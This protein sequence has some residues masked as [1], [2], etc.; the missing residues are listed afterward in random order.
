MITGEGLQSRAAV[1]VVASR[2][3]P[4]CGSGPPR[5]SKKSGGS[6]AADSRWLESVSIRFGIDWYECTIMAKDGC[7]RRLREAVLRLCSMW[8]CV[9]PPPRIILGTRGD[10]ALLIGRSAFP[11]PVLLP[12]CDQGAAT[13]TKP[14]DLVLRLGRLTTS[15]T[16]VPPYS[17][18]CFA[19]LRP[20]V[21]VRRAT[22]SRPG[23]E[24]RGPPSEPLGSAVAFLEL[25]RD[26]QSSIAASTHGDFAGRLRRGFQNSGLGVSPWLVRSL[27]IRGGA[28]S[29][30]ADQANTALALGAPLEVG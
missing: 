9:S 21:G 1:M 25:R 18:P 28:P 6:P 14:R 11:N 17:L 16:A 23:H 7:M 3:W 4:G 26:G 20:L 10:E 13:G 12:S 30:S 5:R 19:R 22:S 8:R 29:F 27:G 15:V 2:M 24:R